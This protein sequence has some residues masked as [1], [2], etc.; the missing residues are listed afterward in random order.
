M[1][2]DGSEDTTAVLSALEIVRLA[3]D[4]IEKSLRGLEDSTSTHEF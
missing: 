4:E 2:D 1:F 3:S